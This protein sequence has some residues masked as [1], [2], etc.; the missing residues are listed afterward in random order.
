MAGRDVPDESPGGFGDA[1]ERTGVVV[2]RVWLE[3]DDARRG[4]RARISLVPDIEGR[5]EESLAAGSTEEILEAVRRFVD[6]FV[7]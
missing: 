1:T 4:L 3:G 5:E 7:A 2:I 6:E